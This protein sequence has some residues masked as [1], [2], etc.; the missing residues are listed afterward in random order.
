MSVGSGV[1]DWCMTQVNL[2]LL[3]GVVVVCI[4][5]SCDAVPS[6]VVDENPW[7]KKKERVSFCCFRGRS[8][9]S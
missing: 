4:T 2:H 8:F 9:G 3:V 6:F 1:V 5:V 7:S